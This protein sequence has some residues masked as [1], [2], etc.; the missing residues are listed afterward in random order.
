MTKL[1][2]LVRLFRRQDG[3]SLVMAVGVLGVLS[4]SGATMIQY[5]NSNNRSSE[6]SKANGSAYDLAEAGI[7]EMTS[8]LSNPQNNALNPYLLPST[9][10]AYAT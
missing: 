4:M 6:Y 1:L 3:I 10:S 2:R 8:I 5:A 7:N 9:T